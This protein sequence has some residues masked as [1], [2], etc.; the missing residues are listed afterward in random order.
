MQ[1][2][3]ATETNKVSTNI[4]IGNCRYDL[5][6][7]K[8]ATKYYTEALKISEIIKNENES[9]K[10][11]LSALNN[12]GVVYIVLEKTDEALKYF[13]DALEINKKTAFHDF[14][15]NKY[16]TNRSTLNPREREW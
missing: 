6:N 14:N 2:E 7:L 11:K 8:E 15:S 16:S 12:I 10:G 1:V 13:N 9:L 3:G 5:Y 4:L